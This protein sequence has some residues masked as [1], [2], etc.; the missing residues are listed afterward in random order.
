MTLPSLPDLNFVDATVEKIGRDEDK[1]IPILQAIQSHYR[2]L[3]AEALRRV[4]RVSRISPSA[5]TG[6][7]T[8]YSQ[9]RHRPS[10]EHTIC[11]CHGTACH[12]KGAGM[13]QD[14]ILY[15]L[16]IKHGQDTDAD[17]KFTVEKVACLGC[18]TLAPVVQISSLT[19]GHLTPTTV[20]E[21]LDDFRKQLSAGNLGGDARGEKTLPQVEFPESAMRGEVYVG[22]G[23]CCQA[24]GSMKVR[25]AVFQAVSDYKLP[26]RIK[27]VG[28][29][30]MCH[31]AP[32]LEIVETPAGGNHVPET[33]EKKHLYTQ[34]TPQSVER[35]ITSH[36]PPAGFWQR[37][38]LKAD[39]FLD[40]FFTDEF[41][42]TGARVDA[43][44]TEFPEWRE[45]LADGNAAEN[46]AEKTPQKPIF[47]PQEEKI[48]EFLGPQKHVAT[49]FCGALDPLDMREY[50][51]HA[52]FLGLEKTREMTAAEVIQTLTDSGLRGRGG[53]GFPTGVKWSRVAAENPADGV[54]YIVC[55][56]D[57]GDPGAFMDRM[58]LESFPYRILE[59]MLIAARA[60]GAKKAF[61][62]IRAEYPLALARVRHAIKNCE[63]EGLLDG[64]EFEIKEGA[65]AFVCG[66]ETALLESMEGRRGMPRMRPPFPAQKGLWGAPT[67]VNN[68]ETFAMI[69]WIFRQGA[70]AFS[71]LGTARSKGTKVFAL[72]GK[73]A[74]GGLIEV[75]M[76]I[77]L[78]QIVEEIGGGVA[79]GR[80]LKAVQVGGPSG[81][82]I[83]AAMCD[84]P[85]DFEAL[86]SVGAMM[87]SG[88]L[89]VLD[90]RDCMV[91]IAR[92]FLQFTQEQ[93]CGKC[94]FCRVGTKRM[95]EILERICGGTG[96]QEDLEELETLAKTIKSSS[97]C[98]LGKTAPNPVLSTLK[99][100]RDEYEAHLSGRCPGGKCGAL[101]RYEIACNC[102]G[103][104]LC[105]QSC[106]TAAIT[107]TPYVRHE[108][109]REKCVRCDTCRNVCPHGAVYVR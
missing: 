90:E 71:S 38:A 89:V 23:S 2:Y 42:P 13:V 102:T 72:A 52:G 9:F 25:E 100:F 7:A 104:T 80:A 69:P 82:C 63:A 101:I 39:A 98:G 57:E 46:P 79:G 18:C 68:V 29:V 30:G 35:I 3:P 74:R 62:Y 67:L 87:G 96:V 24:Q 50:R 76:G 107:P 17:G 86:Q 16:G 1:I 88:G 94:T 41:T 81:G 84:T 26:V 6:V 99:Y 56:G 22:L 95:L 49:E 61:L 4:C 59:G 33:P 92:Y 43:A 28:C 48:C 15:Q 44:G 70:A 58:L 47:N 19:Y 51:N 27:R 53:G 37:M 8:F 5:I 21:M 73:V 45:R 60:V 106:P 75:P 109:N 20:P 65:G 93:S 32:L 11:V 83:P 31:Q 91:D 36:F 66:E 85:I 10:G 12:V 54:K 34:V 103:C 64:V 40:R 105:A 108:I 78:R 14:A 77:T 55:N 97:L